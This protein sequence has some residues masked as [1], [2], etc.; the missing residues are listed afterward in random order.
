MAVST[1]VS[2][3]IPLYNQLAYTKGCL[4][5]LRQTTPEEIEVILIDN[6]SSDDTGQYLS[7]LSG[8]N[9]ISNDINRGCSGAWNQGV[10]AAKGEWLVILNNDVILS[11]GWLEGLLNAAE[12]WNLDIVSPAIREGELNYQLEPYSDEITTL[13]RNVIRRDR[14]NGI[15]FMVHQR[16][17][18]N[19]G[20]FDEN[21]RIGQ[22]EDADFFLRAKTAGF[23]LGTVGSSFLH[24]F[25]SITQ[26][27]LKKPKVVKSYALE[28]KA[29]FIRKWNLP[30]WKRCAIRNRNKLENRLSSI[31]ER[32]RYR[33]SLFEKW[34]N[35]RL[36]YE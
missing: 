18:E 8:V 4:E 22:Y 33:H 14:A 35:G 36:R 16:V 10:R 34:I 3:I 1:L 23:H 32:L 12:H 9:V 25:G 5:S 26:K 13:M 27:S 21:F 6:A 7:S 15:C 11:L 29:Y 17:F 31:C 24:H 30:W 28:N 2:I 20:L 19:I